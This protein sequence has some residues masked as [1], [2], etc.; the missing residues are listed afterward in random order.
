MYTR[1]FTVRRAELLGGV[2]TSDHLPIV[3]ELD[4]P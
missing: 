3:V 2:K 4:R 1:G